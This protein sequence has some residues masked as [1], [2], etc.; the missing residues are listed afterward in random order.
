MWEA[1]IVRVAYQDYYKKTAVVEMWAAMK[2]TP[3]DAVDAVRLNVQSGAAVGFA[4]AF[5]TQISTTRLGLI[6]NSVIRL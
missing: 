2:Q 6:R 5:L 3:K 4:G 1:F